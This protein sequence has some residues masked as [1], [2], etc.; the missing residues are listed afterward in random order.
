MKKPLS[1][2]SQA[3]RANA[4][5]RHPPPGKGRKTQNRQATNAIPSEIESQN[6][7]LAGKHPGTPFFK[8]RKGRCKVTSARQNGGIFKQTR[9]ARGQYTKTTKRQREALIEQ[10]QKGE[11]STRSVCH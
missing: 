7:P 5:T 8:I 4:G 6:D 1:D 11:H 10:V 9:A 3:R 2:I